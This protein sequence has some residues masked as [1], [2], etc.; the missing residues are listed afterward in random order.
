MR[1]LSVVLVS[2]NQE[3][4]IAR[5]LRSVLKETVR[6]ADREIVL[7]DSASLDGTVDVASMYPV[8]FY[9][10]IGTRG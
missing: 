9:G 3:W 5:L 10:S 4:N 6:M 8:Q 7:V 2:K 1:Q